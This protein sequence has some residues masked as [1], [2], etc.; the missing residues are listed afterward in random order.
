MSRHF[1]C[2]IEYYP[3]N[4]DRPHYFFRAVYANSDSEAKS[5]VMNLFLELSLCNHSE[6]LGDAQVMEYERDD[7]F[8]VD[9]WPERLLDILRYTKQP[10]QSRLYNFW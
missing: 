10:T 8:V 5:M 3:N 6:I 1:V 7:G 9:M 4:S 2:A